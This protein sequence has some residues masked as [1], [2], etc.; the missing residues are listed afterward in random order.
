MTDDMWQSLRREERPIVVY[1]MGNG[2]DKLF[3]RLSSL[4]VSV[5]DVFASDG[6]VR[7]HS[8]RGMRVLSFSEIKAK[9]EDFCILLSFASRLPEVI[10]MLSAIAKEYTLYVPDM[11]VAGVEEYLDR[12]FYNANYEAITSATESLADEESRNCFA[13]VVRFK[14]SG[15]MEYLEGAYS[16]K[17]ELYSLI[18]THPVRN[19]IDAGA[20]N[21]DTLREAVEY[22]RGLRRAVAIEPDPKN[23]KKLIKY[24]ESVEC[25][26]VIPVNAAAYSEDGTG[27]MASSGNRH[28]TLTATASYEHREDS[29]PLITIDSIATEKVDYIKY[30]VEGAEAEALVGSLATIR[31]YSPA[32]RIAVYHR[33]CDIFSIINYMREHTENYDFYVRR[34]RC[35]PAWEIDLI[36]IPKEVDK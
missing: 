16:T 22:F 2:A 14:L 21:G 35:L 13:S 18:N 33:S 29:V 9:Y 12:D 11:P 6:F 27:N 31:K 34:T 26:E 15:K 20:Y 24:T 7:G 8:Y 1:G 23:F 17:E 28:S 36:M 25:V 5:A 4:G 10:D 3:D 30:D 19:I 32:L